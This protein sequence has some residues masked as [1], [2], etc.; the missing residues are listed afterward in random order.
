MHVV[1]KSIATSCD[2]V[3]VEFKAIK[4]GVIVG[5]FHNGIFIFH[6]IRIK[7]A[8]HA[9]LGMNL[10]LGLHQFQVGT[11]GVVHIQD[12]IEVGKV[13]RGQ[14]SRLMRDWRAFVSQAP[15]ADLNG[16]MVRAFTYVVVASITKT[17][18]AW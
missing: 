12:E 13:R 17:V 3:V 16:P 4:I 1:Q 6:A 7:R 14:L 9:D 11:I 8:Q 15:L 10:A 18:R 2:Q 5:V